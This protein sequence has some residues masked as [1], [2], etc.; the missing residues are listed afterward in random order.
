MSKREAIHCYDYVNHPYDKVRDA[1][2]AGALTVF[3]RATK[4]ASSRA[5]DLAAAL[6]VEVGALEVGTDIEIVVHKIEDTPRAG[7]MAA[8]MRVVFEWKAKTSSRLFPLMRA[9][10]QVF[11]LTPSETQ[12]AF[13]GQYDPPLGVFGSAVDVLVGNRVAEACIHQFV[14]EVAEYLR[15]ALRRNAAAV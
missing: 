3:S 11:P 4:G 8:G 1:L 9:E 12:L 2:K 14:T 13:A 15:S 7:K 10:L 6:H 5:E